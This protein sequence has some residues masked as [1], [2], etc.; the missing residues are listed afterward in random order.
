MRRTWQRE[1]AISS[2]AVRTLFVDSMFIKI[3]PTHVLYQV[4]LFDLFLVIHTSR[5]LTGSPLAVPSRGPRGIPSLVVEIT[6]DCRC[7]Y[8]D[9]REIA[10][11]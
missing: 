4:R 8:R 2:L 1:V 7:T 5:A 6:L 9:C 3:I 11:D 10:G